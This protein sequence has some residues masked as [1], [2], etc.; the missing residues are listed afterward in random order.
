MCET[1]QLVSGYEKI[2]HIALYELLPNYS[3]IPF[4]LLKYNFKEILVNSKGNIFMILTCVEL[5]QATTPEASGRPPNQLT[6]NG[7]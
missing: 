4:D 3:N 1:L 6:S 2:I 5:P 7:R